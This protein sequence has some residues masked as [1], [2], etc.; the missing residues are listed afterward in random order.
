MRLVPRGLR[1]R[2]LVA[3]LVV[4][5]AAI[6][7]VLLGVSL[8]GPGYFQEAMGHRPG[9]PAG[10]QMDALIRAA[11]HEAI[12]TALLAAAV[13]ALGAAVVV[14][15]AISS[16]I[17]SPVSRLVGAARR[18]AGGHYAERVPMEGEGEVAELA[19]AFN[20]MSASLES[21]E[22][23]RMQLVGDVA[24][25]LRTP[26]ATL[27]GYLEGLQDSVIEAKPETWELLRRETHRLTR[28]VGDLSELWRGGGR[29]PPPPTGAARPGGGGGGG[30]CRCEG[31]PCNSERWLRKQSHASCRARRSMACGSR[32]LSRPARSR[33]PIGT[34][35][36]RSSETSSPTLCVT[37]RKAQVS[38]SEPAGPVRA[39]SARCGPPG[40][41]SA[42]SSSGRSLSAST[43]STLRDPAARGEPA[44]VSRSCERWPKRWAAAP[45]PRA[46]GAATARRSECLCPQRRARRRRSSGPHRSAD[47]SCCSRT[48]CSRTR[49]LERILR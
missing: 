36:C 48:S 20:L 8:V 1:G 29:P 27:D 23:R 39:A 47:A 22:R 28:L 12:R 14:S 17:A 21:T 45:G 41:D 43:V 15:L 11:F 3:N 18:I 24:H 7:T 16:R 49:G 6:G 40:Q 26:L 5:G 32:A 37:R 44:S 19:S 31:S 9:D 4:A 38:S 25:E 42:P 46:M 35:L 10:R 30:R 13:T 33:W 34:A 2:L